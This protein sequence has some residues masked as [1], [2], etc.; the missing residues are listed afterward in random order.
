M[1]EISLS[2]I[3]EMAEIIMIVYIYVVVEKFLCHKK[4]IGMVTKAVI[5]KVE[6]NNIIPRKGLSLFSSIYFHERTKSAIAIFCRTGKI[7]ANVVAYQ[8]RSENSG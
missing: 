6:A 4:Y 7:F 8:I 3:I 2:P 5:W 1:F